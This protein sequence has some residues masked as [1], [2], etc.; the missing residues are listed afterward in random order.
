MLAMNIPFD[1]KD[2]KKQD[3]TDREESA[4]KAIEFPE[5]EGKE[6]VLEQEDGILHCGYCC[7]HEAHVG[8]LSM[9]QRTPI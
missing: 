7:V 4:S 5:Y 2:G 3:D 1:K 8:Q 9:L 6:F